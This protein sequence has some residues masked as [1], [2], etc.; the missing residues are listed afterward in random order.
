M[1]WPKRLCIRKTTEK[2]CEDAVSVINGTQKSFHGS[3]C[4]LVFI[5][6]DLCYLFHRQGSGI[7]NK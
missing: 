4:D 1:K 6:I 3:L 5:Q 7:D 2:E